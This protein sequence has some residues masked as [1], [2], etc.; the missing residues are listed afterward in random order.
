MRAMVAYIKWVGKDVVKENKPLGSGMIE[1]PYLSRAADPNQGS[2]VYDAKCQR[3]HGKNGEGILAFDSKGYIY[4]PLWGPHSYN[5]GA[6]LYRL[7]RLAA[8]IK[9]NMPY[10]LALESPQLSDEESWDLAAFISSQPRPEKI[11]S[12]D[13]PRLENKPPDH[14]FG[15]CIDPFTAQQHKFGPFGPIKEAI[16]KYK[17]GIK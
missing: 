3:C 10:D 4:P 12:T 17:A 6:G 15:P 8:F 11:F 16:Q 5:T 7:S 13:W 9:Y 14:P 2:L 1:L